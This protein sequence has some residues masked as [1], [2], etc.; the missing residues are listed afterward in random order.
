[1]FDDN[2]RLLHRYRE[3]E[4]AIFGNVDDYAFFIAALLDLYET[5]FE[6]NYLKQALR[7]NDDFIKH[8]WDNEG[9]GFFFTP[10]Y[11]EK[12]IARQ[13]E[14]YDGAIPSGNSVAM[15]NLLRIARITAKTEYEEKAERIN[16]TFSSAIRKYP[17]GFTQFLI[18]LDFAVGPSKEI[19]LSG[20]DYHSFLSHIYEK[21]IPAKIV[22][23]TPS[24]KDSAL[25]FA[26]YLKDYLTTDD[27]TKVFVCENYVCNLPVYSVE[28]LE[29]VLK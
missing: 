3:G 13:K 1:M 18:A 25:G 23:K 24:E 28:A 10:E 27:K 8:F 29:Q 2:G 19:I 9:G 20:N 5:N 15:L 17:S 22:L 7:L 6:I 4:A 11:G 16:K 14:I 12:L 21:F 26:H